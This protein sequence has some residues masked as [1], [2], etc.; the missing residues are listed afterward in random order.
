MGIFSPSGAGQAGSSGSSLEVTNPL[1]TNVSVPLAATEVPITFPANTKRF[2]IKARKVGDV[3]PV[4]Q[5]SYISGNSGTIFLTI[6]GGAFYTEGE[7]AASSLTIYI[8]S[9]LPT[10][11]IEVVSWT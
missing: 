7:I 1:V 6:P 11:T 2:L 8:Q 9:N 10:T 5:V 4:T 3:Y